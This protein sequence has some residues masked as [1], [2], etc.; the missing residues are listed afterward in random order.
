MV[1]KFPLILGIILL[2]IGFLSQPLGWISGNIAGISYVTI[3]LI[4]GGIFFAIGLFP[5]RT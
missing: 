5:K 3:L 2:A 1:H 4:A